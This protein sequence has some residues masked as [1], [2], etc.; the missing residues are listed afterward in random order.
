MATSTVLVV[1]HPPDTLLVRRTV[2][3]VSGDVLSIAGVQSTLRATTC[4]RAVVQM[5]TVLN[6]TVRRVY[7]SNT[8]QK[9]R[10]RV[11]CTTN[12]MCAIEAG[13]AVEVTRCIRNCR[14]PT[15]IDDVDEHGWSPM[16]LACYDGHDGMVKELLDAGA[17][18][19]MVFR[20]VDTRD[21]GKCHIDE[22]APLR[23]AAMGG[24][25]AVVAH[26]LAHG[27]HPGD[28]SSFTS[29]LHCAAEGC[30]LRIFQL[31]CS[32]GAV[33]YVWYPGLG[34]NCD[35]LHKIEAM[36]Q[37][38]EES[39]D[40]ATPLHHLCVLNEARTRALLRAGADVHACV[41]PGAPTPL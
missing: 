37:W 8:W 10:H 24:H 31:L 27:A 40:W 28:G 38:I 18:P 9:E 2:H 35:Q 39:R 20:I 41:R 16:L 17:A 7:E 1:W 34:S 3:K 4:P 11:A 15:T 30:H 6:A 13:D 25:D 12:L 21:K 36:V 23:A 14:D 29:P 5:Y 32:Y 33:P 26:L 22:N 19:T